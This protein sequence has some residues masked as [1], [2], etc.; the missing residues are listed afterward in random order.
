MAITKSGK[1]HG[2]TPGNKG[3]R[4]VTVNGSHQVQ[5][6]VSPDLH[7]R[8]DE[9]AAANNVT[10]SEALRLVFSVMLE[11]PRDVVAAFFRDPDAMRVRFE[12]R[13]PELPFTPE[14]HPG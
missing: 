9:L 7:R 5:I 2:G 4:P 13:E 10:R 11:N 14:L 8:I 3:G 1:Y 6:R 12:A